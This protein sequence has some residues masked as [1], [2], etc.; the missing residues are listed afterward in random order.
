MEIPLHLGPLK[1]E[2]YKIHRS[3]VRWLC[4]PGQMCRANQVVAYFNLSIEPAGT[5][6]ISPVPFSCP[7][8][9]GA[10]ISPR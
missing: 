1:A 10:R 7:V 5:R 9:L 6:A 2:G 3:G 8:S 4:E